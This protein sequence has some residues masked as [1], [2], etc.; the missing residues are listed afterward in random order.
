M[1]ITHKFFI[2]DKSYHEIRQAFREDKIKHM[3][4]TKVS[5]GYHIEIKNPSLDADNASFI[6][7]MCLKYDAK[8][9]ASMF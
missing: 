7:Y 8:A 3:P 2:P 6:S 4:F 5:G 1:K 9:Y